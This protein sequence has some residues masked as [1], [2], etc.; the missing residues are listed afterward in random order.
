MTVSVYN[1]DDNR[2]NDTDMCPTAVSY[3]ASGRGAQRGAPGAGADFGAA[4]GRGLATG[5]LDCSAAPEPGHAMAV[6]TRRAAA[7]AV[8]P[9]AA[10]GAAPTHP[11]FYSLL[12]DL[13]E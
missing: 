6:V 12:E 9:A 4:E 11:F 10:A 3:I 8:R 1:G 7:A 13:L 2:M 5:G